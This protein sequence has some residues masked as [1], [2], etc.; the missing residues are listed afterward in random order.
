MLKHLKFILKK[1][2]DELKYLGKKIQQFAKRKLKYC[3][4][5]E[6]FYQ[7]IM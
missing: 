2:E 1:S 5:M 7:H 4:I 3:D 6:G